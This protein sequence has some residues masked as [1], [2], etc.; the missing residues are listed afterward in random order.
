MKLLFLASWYPNSAASRNGLFIWQHANALAKHSNHQV[1]LVAAVANSEVHKLVVIQRNVEGVTH[2]VANYPTASNVF[3]RSWR[4]L[5]ALHQAILASERASG[6]SDL[7]VVNVLWRAGIVAWFYQICFSRP[8][9]II[10]HWSGYLHE[11]QG[12]KGFYLKYFTRLIADRAERILTVSNYLA[13]SMR[14]RSLLNRYYVLPNVINTEVFKPADAKKQRLP[15]SLLHVSNLAAEKNFEFVFQLWE[16]MKSAYPDLE[17]W[18][19]GAYSVEQKEDYSTYKNIR[20]LGFLEEQELAIVYQRATALC[21]PSH[22]ETFSIVIGEAL[23][24][25]CPVLASDLPTFDF[26]KTARNFYPIVLQD[27]SAWQRTLTRIIKEQRPE[28]DFEFIHNNFSSL[29]VSEKMS[30]ILEGMKF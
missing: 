1:S 20:W 5:W 27:S 2:W 10:E 26:Y 17:L 24:C 22:F 4:Y 18:V 3:Q 11:G 13:N 7:L 6:K 12:Y 19:A 28:H 25:G 8:Y 30:S 14:A 21:M 9:I 23:A 15:H 29:K 16:Q